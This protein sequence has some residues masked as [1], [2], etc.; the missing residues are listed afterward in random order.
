MLRI[1][2][3]SKRKAKRDF[4]CSKKASHVQLC[5]YKG[6]QIRYP[7]ERGKDVGEGRV[8][9]NL[10][11]LFPELYRQRFYTWETCLKLNSS[12]RPLAIDF[13]LIFWTELLGKLFQII[14]PDS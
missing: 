2:V 12:E 8:T 6:F 11:K 13:D 4:D 9:R 10:R 14:F 1:S 7:Q 5:W 3:E